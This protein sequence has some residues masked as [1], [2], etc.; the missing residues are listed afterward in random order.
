MADFNVDVAEARGA[1]TQP[2]SPVQNHETKQMNPWVPFAANAAGMLMQYAKDK[3]EQEKQAAIDSV[4]ASFVR[5]QTALNDAVAQGAKSPVEAAARARANFS[6]Y[7]AQHPSLIKLFKESNA[8]LVEHTGIGEFKEEEQA[9]Q[10]RE[11]KIESDMVAAGYP[12]Y[13]GMSPQ[14]KEEMKTAFLSTRKVEAELEA[15][16]KANAERR[17][18]NS[19]ERTSQDWFA[20]Q[21]AVRLLSDLG[22]K[23][24]PAT[25]SFLQ[26]VAKMPNKEE[27]LLKSSQ[28]FAMIDGALAALSGVNP[29]LASNWNKLFNELRQNS[30]K[31]IK[32]QLGAEASENLLKEIKNRAQL[33]ALSDPAMQGAYATNALIPQMVSTTKTINKAAMDV[34]TRFTTS[35]GVKWPVVGNADVEADVYEGLNAN[36]RALEG[37]KVVNKETVIREL[38]VAAGNVMTQV[39]RA[40]AN[41][42]KGSDLKEVAN[43]IAK[44]E[45][46]IM[47]GKGIINKEQMAAAKTSFQY[48]YEQEVSNGVVQ[49]LSE[50][51]GD[52][53]YAD[54][55]EFK[56]VG[57]GVALEK[58]FEDVKPG[59]SI[60]G[61][62]A[63]K[64]ING[65]RMVEIRKE[66]QQLVNDL[67]PVTKAINVLVKA[68][69][70]MEGHRDY[71]LYWEENKHRILPNI[72]S[73]PE[74][75]DQM[76]NRRQAVDSGKTV[77]NASDVQ[78]GFELNGWV[79]QG[80]DP[81]DAKSWKRK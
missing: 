29:D 46:G 27:A 14:T 79:F 17:A 7:A 57:N 69:A 59:W 18:Q 10:D 1:G 25:I 51:L 39:D 54:A 20:K 34:M 65:E 21:K 74:L 66:Q 68:G 62:G 23:H 56:W 15:I 50:K 19:E 78:A 13:E 47:V 9:V 44:P 41:G 64:N 16:R 49:K 24:I 55:V 32:G 6:K 70:H 36:V 81:T 75:S 52:K 2:L 67:T 76:K 38:G 61:S 22:D 8:A 12:I 58:K 63:F 73:D 4:V 3:K 5:E 40:L 26:D 60:G 45:F 37:N 53:T 48:L 30:E 42:L 35:G 31:L 28:H 43:W 71:G 11:R 72:F 33:M 77:V 80:G